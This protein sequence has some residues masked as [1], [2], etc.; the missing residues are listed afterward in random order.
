MDF[1]K[2]FGGSRRAPLWFPMKVVFKVKFNQSM[3][4]LTNN[5][6]CCLQAH[7]P[8]GGRGPVIIGSVGCFINV[9]HISAS[10]SKDPHR[11]PKSFRHWSIS[12]SPAMSNGFP[13]TRNRITA[14]VTYRFNSSVW[15]NC[16]P[17]FANFLENLLIGLGS[18]LVQQQTKICKFLIALHISNSWNILS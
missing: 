10:R 15:K 17:N 11:C 13:K 4:H 3:F 2:N 5:Q 18:A 14:H 12:R 1:R 16:H 6:N 8:S 7:K 9:P